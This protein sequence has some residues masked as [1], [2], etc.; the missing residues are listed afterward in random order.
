M[1]KCIT[2]DLDD[3][4]WAVDPVITHA[5]N[6]LYG[7]LDEHAPGFTRE[8]QVGDFPALREQVLMAFPETAHSVTLIRLR[9]LEIGLRQAGYSETEIEVLVPQA[10]DIFIAARNEVTFFPYVTE[11]LS[12]LKEYE[13]R[14]GALSNGNAEVNRAGLGDW[15]DFALNAHMVG[16]EK[17][18]PAMFQQMLASEKLRPEEVIHIGDNPDHD[19]AGAQQLGIRTIWVNLKQGSHKTGET[20]DQVVTCLSEVFDAVTAIRAQS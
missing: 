2:F 14:I 5:N 12:Q 18:H 16:H 1:I 9:Q 15:F 20:A 4:L 6:T 10:F 13:Y 7:W 8:Y 17:P 3:T 11:M 19:V